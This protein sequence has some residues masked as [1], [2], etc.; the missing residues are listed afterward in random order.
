MSHAPQH[1]YKRNGYQLTDEMVVDSNSMMMHG[2]PVPPG[3][4]FHTNVMMGDPYG[5]AAVYN[6]AAAA[7]DPASA[8]QTGAP[9]PAAGP[10]PVKLSKIIACEIKVGLGYCVCV[11]VCV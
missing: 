11:C 3:M 2:A 4:N 9:L 10:A 5:Q 8:A 7:A 1:V 6:P